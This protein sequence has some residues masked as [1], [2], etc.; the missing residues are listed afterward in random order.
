MTTDALRER[1]VYWQRVLRLQDWDIE[2]RML[3]QH[4]IDAA[5]PLA[6]GRNSFNRNYRTSC[7]LVADPAT[8]TSDHEAAFA[9]QAYDV[10]RTLVHELVHLLAPHVT[11]STDEWEYT[12]EG[13]TRALIGLERREVAV[14]LDGLQAGATAFPG[15][16]DLLDAHALRRFGAG[17]FSQAD[18]GPQA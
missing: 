1:L 3:P 8:V 9:G 13:V 5:S 18:P 14:T 17:G 16:G 15:S 4:H 7:I 6:T 12:V 2:V 10:E 11:S